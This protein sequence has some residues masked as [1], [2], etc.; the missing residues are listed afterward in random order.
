MSKIDV[1]IHT[2]STNKASHIKFIPKGEYEE[3]DGKL[4]KTTID[5]YLYVE[6]ATEFG[7]PS[8][9]LYVTTSETPKDGD[10]CIEEISGLFGPYEEGD[11]VQNPRKVVATDDLE[12]HYKGVFNEHLQRKTFGDVPQLS[13]EFKQAWVR[14]MN[15]GTPIV[16]AMMEME[17]FYIKGNYHNKCSVCNKMFTD[18]DKL[19]FI[20][21]ECG[22]QPKLNPQ[23][24][25]TILPVKEKMYNKTEMIAYGKLAFEVGRNF[26]LTGENNL[27]EIE[28]DL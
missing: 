11:I 6:E 23:G 9:F 24:Y 26:Q 28:Q 13:P 10:Y 19:G 5:K 22:L 1:K 20:C 21:S 18:T 2:L 7:Y 3:I 8:T 16:D 25:V 27:S 14:E 4:V 15:N 12:L 17:Q